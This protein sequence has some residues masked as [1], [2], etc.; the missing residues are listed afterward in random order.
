MTLSLFRFHPRRSAALLGLLGAL[1]L[2]L[3][4]PAAAAEPLPGTSTSTSQTPAPTSA[5]PH[6]AEQT[7]TAALLPADLSPWG[8]YQS[9]D[10][11]V[12]GVMLGLVLASVLTWTIWLS[13]SIEL[14]SARRRL[15]RDLAQLLQARSL[16]A[17]EAA[18]SADGPARRLLQ[19]AREELQ[20]SAQAR[21]LEGIKA[22]IGFRL[23]RWLAG[24]NRQLAQGTGVLASIGSIAPFVG[25]FGTVWGIM[26]SFIGIAAAQTSN[27]AVVA[28]GIAEA[29][30]ATA[31]GLVAAIPAVL[32]YNLFARALGNHKAELGDA[33]AQVL[34]LASRDLDLP[35]AAVAASQQKVQCA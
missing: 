17:A 6:T 22:R 23:E 18:A 9:A 26:N 19:Q 29:L 24:R 20:L 21:D 12:R 13:K 33:A 34:L 30:L 25:L 7:G 16:P 5:A 14:L 2:G 27:L 10:P 31:L 4:N 28:P 32:I 1:L 35:A 8:M 11:L 15:R 3:G